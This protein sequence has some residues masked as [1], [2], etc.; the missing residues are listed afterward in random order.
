MRCALC[1]YPIDKDEDR[2][3]E[4]YTTD[5]KRS[6]DVYHEWCHFELHDPNGLYSMS[7]HR[8]VPL[9][10]ENEIIDIDQF[11]VPII[12]EL[13]SLGQ[14]TMFCCQ[15]SPNPNETLSQGYLALG[16]PSAIDLSRSVLT[17]YGLEITKEEPFEEVFN[18]EISYVFRF[19][20]LTPKDLCIICGEVSQLENL[21]ASCT[22]SV[23]AKEYDFEHAI[24][25][26]KAIKIYREAV[27]KTNE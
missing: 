25:I 4:T 14:K 20:Y 11:M 10:Y 2:I 15:G 21:C 19:K 3:R 6:T 7:E 12:E 26:A 27:A 18:P 1:F 16:F 5:G 9:L 22:R 8:T 23:L 17:N 24:R 13:W